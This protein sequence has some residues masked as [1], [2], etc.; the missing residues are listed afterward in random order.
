MSWPG[1]EVALTQKRGKAGCM[2][3]LEKVECGLFECPS[4]VESQAVSS[5]LDTCF[6][7]PDLGALSFGTGK[8]G[9]D[10]LSVRLCTHASPQSELSSIF[11]SVA[12]AKMDPY[13]TALV[14][15]FLPPFLGTI[16]ATCN[17]KLGF[18]NRGS[19]AFRHIKLLPAEK[20]FLPKENRKPD[21]IKG[22][23]HT[24]GPNI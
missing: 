9:L 15:S 18:Q 2:G 14:P 6:P 3:R 20:F 10:G 23:Q 7:A 16:L 1:T 21:T 11:P 19:K 4:A 8:G 17:W 22:A 12:F 5:G 13:L 24:R